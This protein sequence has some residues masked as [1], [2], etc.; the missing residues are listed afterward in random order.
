MTFKCRPPPLAFPW[1]IRC[2]LFI[3]RFRVIGT[4]KTG[5]SFR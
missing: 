2:L 3:I 1:T 5:I 4:E